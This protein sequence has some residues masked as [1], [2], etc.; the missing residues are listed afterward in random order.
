MR[1]FLDSKKKAEQFL[2]NIDDYE[3]MMDGKITS[4]NYAHQHGY[5]VDA[6]GNG[7]TT[8]TIPVNFDNPHSHTITGYQV[9]ASNGHTHKVYDAGVSNPFVDNRQIESR[10]EI[11]ESQS[12][13]S[14]YNIEDE[15]N[16]GLYLITKGLVMLDMESDKYPI[17]KT[18]KNIDKLL[19]EL[20]KYLEKTYG[21]LDEDENDF[22]IQDF[23]RR[24]Q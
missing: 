4:M 21:Y 2:E 24:Y 3:G 17:L 23:D 15:E 19:G 22:L 20:G 9:N 8:T 11:K 12:E 7:I 13:S 18:V 10:E 6:D 5:E 16:E 14:M 1:N